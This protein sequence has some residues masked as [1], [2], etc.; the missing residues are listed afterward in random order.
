MRLS[1]EYS[2]IIVKTIAGL[3][4][5]IDIYLHGSRVDDQKRGGDIDL[6]LLCASSSERFQ[7]AAL[8]EKILVML[9]DLIGDQRIDLT[10]IE[11][12]EL[13]TEAIYR[14]MLK[15]AVKLNEPGTALG[16]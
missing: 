11:K 16:Q 9:K 14:E 5:N 7:A 1:H 15:S 12:S 6:L 2:E 4:P 3:I 13:T 10:I 8:R